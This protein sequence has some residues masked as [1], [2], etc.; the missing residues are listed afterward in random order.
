[1]TEYAGERVEAYVL[2]VGG[3][4]RERQLG[5]TFPRK[6]PRTLV[7]PVIR[8]L[9]AVYEDAALPGE[10]FSAAVGRLGADVFF[11]V[12]AQLLDGTHVAL[13]AARGGRLLVIG[14]G[15]SGARL[16]D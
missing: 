10:R 16:V 7:V 15:M 9:L 4:A 12:I 13:P 14:N 11:T 3:N 2:Y 8:V 6:I 5:A 1:M